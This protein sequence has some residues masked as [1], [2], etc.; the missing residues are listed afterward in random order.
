MDLVT[1]ILRKFH[2]VKSLE[3]SVRNLEQSVLQLQRDRGLLESENQKTRAEMA[4]W[5]RFCPHG[6][7]YSPLPSRDEVAAAFS[8]GGYG[9]PFPA[10]DLNTDGQF[11]L[12]K[13][14][15]TFYP[16]LPFPENPTAGRRFHLANPAYGHYDAV[17]LYCMMRRLQ[18]K[19][20]VEV[21]C[22]YS[23]A[24]ILDLNDAL[25]G[26]RLAATFIDPD[27]AQ[28]R[29]LLLPG[30]AN[31]STLIEKPVQEVPNE[32]FES[33][34]AN[35]VL[36]IDTSHVS[37]VGSDVNHLFFK[38]LPAL[39]PGVWVHIHDISVDLEYP[40]DWLEEGRAWNEMYILRAFL[41]YN[42]TFKIMF[43]SALMYNDRHDFLREHMPMCAGGGGGQM[44][45]SKEAAG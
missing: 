4:E 32:V 21:G 19:R 26:G 2:L 12:L 37:K 29:R 25:F 5:T 44:W 24:A 23:S 35:D 14:F 38:V 18:P 34:D 1:Y 30:E 27:L 17:V 33:L 7:F 10:V 16:D 11:A 15:A 31:H 6:H 22:G 41:M 45:L 3:R 36:F 43:S 13:E 39:R 28:F 40:R 42:R 20:I 8:R 9:P